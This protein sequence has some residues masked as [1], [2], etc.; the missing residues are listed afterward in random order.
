MMFLQTVKEPNVHKHWNNCV[1][2]HVKTYFGF[3]EV[4]PAILHTVYMMFVYLKAGF[5][6]VCRKNVLTK[7]GIESITKC[8]II[9]LQKGAI[10]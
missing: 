5:E 10:N 1:L 3:N 2:Y 6:A 8:K 9:H 7:A 4:K